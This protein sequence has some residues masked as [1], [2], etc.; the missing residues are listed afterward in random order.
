MIRYNLLVVLVRRRAPNVLKRN[1]KDFK[2][3]GIL[4]FVAPDMSELTLPSLA[5]PIPYH[6]HYLSRLSLV[7]ALVKAA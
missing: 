7:K 1:D 6:N 2:R 3:P 5:S 4:I